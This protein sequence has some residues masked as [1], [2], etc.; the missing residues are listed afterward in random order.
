MDAVVQQKSKPTKASKKKPP[1]PEQQALEE[2]LACPEDPSGT[3]IKIKV[4]SQSFKD[5]VFGIKTT[6]KMA[7]VMQAFCTRTNLQ[8]H[9]VR[10]LFDGARVNEGS[11]P[12]TLGMEDGDVLDVM[13]SFEGGGG[14]SKKR[15]RED[16]GS[17]AH[18]H[19]TVRKSRAEVLDDLDYY[20][21]EAERE[22]GW[23]NLERAFGDALECY[24]QM[25]LDAAANA[26][27]QSL[28]IAKSLMARSKMDF[29]STSSANRFALEV[30][31]MIRHE[32]VS[33]ETNNERERAASALETIG[34][35]VEGIAKA[36]L[37]AE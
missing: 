21:T 28:L 32:V 20:P 36:A 26:V 7:K 25:R 30:A 27:E 14:S 33:R 12:A 23:P 13:V 35:T 6:T 10:F 3:P 4:S 16:A 1:P 18:A 37:F 9:T 17:D 8:I 15:A 2:A 22:S 19:E 5:L 31:K 34:E 11:T 24:D 29:D